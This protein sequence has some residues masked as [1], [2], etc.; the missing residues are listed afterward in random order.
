[1]RDTGW[2]F[3]VDRGGTF[4]DVV[5]CAPGGRLYAEKL[6]SV[7]PG[8]Y[9]DATVPGIR[10][11]LARA[12]ATGAP[13]ASV[14]VGTTVATNALLE[15][16]GA[17]TALVITQ[18][19]KDALAIGTQERP[20]LFRR[21]IRLPSPL[22]AR[23][24]E[25]RERIRADGV[26]LE[27]LDVESL[28]AELAAARAGGCVSVAIVLLHGWR[29]TA[30]ELAA[31]DAARA[32]GFEAVAVSHQVAPLEGLVPRGQTTVADAYLAILVGRYVATLAAELARE[33]PGASVE[34][35]QSHGGL[36]PA[37]NFRGTNGVLSGPAGG[38]VGMV[39]TG[40]AAG[41]RRLIGFDRAAARD[42]VSHQHQ[43]RIQLHRLLLARDGIHPSPGPRPRPA[44]RG[45]QPPAEGQREEPAEG[46]AACLP[47]QP[48]EGDG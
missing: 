19:L 17:R 1:M 29:Y 18:G 12:A 36:A 11:V 44:H 40:L 20:Q 13:V 22:Y 34:L 33:W 35:M 42:R 7:A 43:R 8:R 23:V 3:W 5:G 39:K 24:I 4:T 41:Y 31:A 16:S 14:R 30:H 2:H 6:L 28:R 37:A 25:A 9:Q 38:L 47:A 46:R 27:A 10:A 15:R 32:A 26:V 48:D 45:G 21:E